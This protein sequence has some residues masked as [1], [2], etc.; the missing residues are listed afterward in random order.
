MVCKPS[1][2]KPFGA[3]DNLPAF[4]IKLFISKKLGPASK[5]I[6]AA[7]VL[8]AVGATSVFNSCCCS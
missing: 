6:F 7:N 5:A 3:V 2:V 4:F 1:D 8:A